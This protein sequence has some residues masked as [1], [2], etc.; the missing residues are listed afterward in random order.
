MRRHLKLSPLLVH[1]PLFIL[2]KILN[3]IVELS[4]PKWRCEFQQALKLQ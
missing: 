3:Y 2:W 1:N 4:S